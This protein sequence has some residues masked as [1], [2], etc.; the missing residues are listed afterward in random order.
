MRT[1]SA[2]EIWQAHQGEGQVRRQINRIGTGMNVPTI[3]AL[4]LVFVLSVIALILLTPLIDGF[5]T[6]EASTGTAT[7]GLPDNRVYEMVTPADNQDADV[8]MPEVF[9]QFFNEGIHTRLPFQVAES[10]EAVAYVASPTAAGFGQSG[11]GLGDEYLARR[12]SGGGWLQE[13]IQPSARQQNNYQG[14]SGDLSVGVLNSGVP[15]EPHVPP[16]AADA[17]GEGYSVLY[18]CVAAA[19]WC[20]APTKADPQPA[21]P[22]QPLFGKP[23]YRNAK[24]FGTNKILVAGKIGRVPA[25]AGGSSGFST[26]AFEADDALIS[27]SGRLETELAEDVEKEIQAGELNSY[28]YAQTNGTLNLVDVLPN[29]KVAPEATYGAPVFEKPEDN[30]PGFG[31]VVSPDGSRMLW[32]DLAP[33]IYEHHVFVRENPSQPESPLGPENECLV[34]S[35]AC[36]VAVSEGAARYWASGDDGR[37]VFYEENGGLYRFDDETDERET[38]AAAGGGVFGVLGA[39]EDGESAYFTAGGVL[40][41]VGSSGQSPVGGSPNLYLWRHGSAPVFVATLSREDGEEADPYGTLAEVS[42]GLRVGDWQP[43]LGQR[44]AAVGGGGGSLVFMSNQSLP[45][46]GFPGG[47]RNGGLDEVYLFEAGVDRLFCVSCSSSGAA[48]PSSSYVAPPDSFLGAAAFLPISWS[49]TARPEWLSS[50]GNRVFFDS[51]VPLVPQDTNNKVDV[52]EWEREGTGGC[53]ASVA[54]N[55]GCV[56]LLSGGSSTSGSWLVG[57][58]ASGDDVFM[59]TRAQLV[60]GDGNDADDL[61]DA[62]VGGVVPVSP[63]ACT[64]TGCQGVPAPPPTFATPSSVTFEG[65]G[66][67]A[68]VAPAPV[69]PKAAVKKKTVRCAKGKHLSHGRCTKQ[70]ARPRRGK[71]ASFSRAGDDRRK[72]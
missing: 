41:G 4:F 2:R 48:P 35:D 14:F 49:D 22:F 31:G 52:Y 65:P 24:E 50:D 58:S 40:A 53:E 19:S 13:V 45:V 37:Y 47:Y 63:P 61:Y 64:G 60:P 20:T 7:E 18:K 17:S 38:L 55:G 30:A 36:T 9:H 28:L 5:A 39:S 54:V 42:T 56:Y 25:L 10:G 21:V 8:Y 72:G 51:V 29:G 6:A 68:P 12:Q 23:L 11:S 69:V 46:V 67:F 66:N 1:T 32:T 59:V 15:G 70:A 27:G 26:L 16:I 34:P 3:L 71:R 33:G 62:R 43:G 44:T 57:A